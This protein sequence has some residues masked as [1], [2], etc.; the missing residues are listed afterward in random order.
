MTISS[1]AGITLSPRQQQRATQLA[2]ERGLHNCTFRVMDAL[3]MELPGDHFDLVWACESGEHMPDK[4]RYVEEMMRVLA[5]G[6]PLTAALLRCP[7]TVCCSDSPSWLLSLAFLGH[8]H[9]LHLQSAACSH[10]ACPA[11]L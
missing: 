9:A 4:Q 11:H 8:P 2:Q 7:A 1:P 5:P 10:A 6:L 3:K